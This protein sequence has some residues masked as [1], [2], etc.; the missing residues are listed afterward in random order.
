MCVSGKQILLVIKCVSTYRTFLTRIPKNI[1]I[2]SET[3]GTVHLRGHAATA[4]NAVGV[5]EYVG[6]LDL[7]K[8]HADVELGGDSL[9]EHQN[10][11]RQFRAETM[12]IFNINQP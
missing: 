4:D 10:W 9:M 8:V 1:I 12:K 5:G 2:S 11:F 7:D 3:Y 6:G